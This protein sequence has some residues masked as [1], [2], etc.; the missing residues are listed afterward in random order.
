[1]KS[2]LFDSIK[3]P[4]I[5]VVVPVYNVAEYLDECINSILAQTY[6]NIEIVLVDDGSTD[7]CPAI[8]DRY[9]AMSDRVKTVHQNNGGLSA[10]RNTGVKVSN[11]TYVGF[12]DSDDY[13]SPVFYEALY[14]AI[15]QSGTDMAAMR[16]GID[17]FDG[18]E[19][20]LGRDVE[21]A[22]KY[23]LLTEEEYQEEILYQKSWAGAVWRLYERGLV[24]KVYF[25]EGLYYEDDETAYRFAHEC[26]KVAVLKATD[27]YAYRQRL[28]GIMRGAF[29][30]KKVESCLE[31][32]RRMRS[33]MVEWYP[34]LSDA[35]CSRCFAI[36]RVVF[37][38]IPNKD[39]TVQ[40][41]MWNEL[42]L[43]S[44]TVIRDPKARKKEKLA[45]AISMMGRVPFRI[46]CNV[47]RC[48]LH[49]Q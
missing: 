8:C 9:A 6:P 26:G 14:R 5:S 42:Q 39:R 21:A 18:D 4:M 17:F 37:S 44:R 23:D 15:E 48:V 12:V 16:C 13:I 36:C 22:S 46:F 40:M 43:Y 27:L 28:T 32:T 45:A 38:Q 2:D 3:L 47:Y 1:M 10:A 7:D 30:P 31:I 41:S 25:P 33:N 35:T 20:N 19:P 34:Q 11:G 29:N 24:E 49:A